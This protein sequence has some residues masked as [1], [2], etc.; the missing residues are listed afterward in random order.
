MENKGEQNAKVAK[1]GAIICII[2][3]ILYCIWP[4]DIIP[5]AIPIAGW[6]D[7]GG[8]L[9]AAFMLFRKSC[10]Y[11]KMIVDMQNRAALE[12]QSEV[13][14]TKKPEETVNSV[15]GKELDLF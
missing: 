1:L 14:S 4:V 8:L 11:A 7:D 15:S 6:I 12:V 2:I 10:S 9:F 3:A 5:D 13:K